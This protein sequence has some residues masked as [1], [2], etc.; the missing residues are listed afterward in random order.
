MWVGLIQSVEGLN[1]P[2]KLALFLPECLQTRMLAFFPV[3]GLKL[4]YP[5]LLG[6]GHCCEE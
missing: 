3:F 5:L 2:E 6:L 4:K 1:R